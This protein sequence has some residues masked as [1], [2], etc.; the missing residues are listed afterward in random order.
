MKNYVQA[1]RRKILISI[2][3]L[4]GVVMLLVPINTKHYEVEYT[5]SPKTTLETMKEVTVDDKIDMMLNEKTNSIKFFANTFL[6]DE[7]VLIAKLKIDYES[8]GYLDNGDNFDSI[9]LNYLLRLESTESSLFK[10]V[11][12]SNVMSKDYIVKVLK[13][14]SNMFGNVD[15]GIAAGIAQ[16]ESGF[17]APFMLSRNNIYGGMS[18]GGLIGYKTIE[19]GV[20]RYVLLLSEGYFGKGLTTV[21]SIGIVFNPTV[22]ENGVKIAKPTWVYNVTN[23]MQEFANVSDVDTTMLISLKNS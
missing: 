17:T 15:F 1:N 7:N 21:E 9:L 8:L 23:A 3:V 11:R 4:I 5:V 6:I 13:Y 18:G 10:N 19:Y 12:V 20:L 2:G 22:N 16:I 14:F